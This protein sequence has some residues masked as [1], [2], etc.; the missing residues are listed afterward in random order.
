MW[1]ALQGLCY[2]SKRSVREFLF[3]YFLFFFLTSSSLVSSAS[4][5][6]GGGRGEG[7]ILVGVCE[8][9]FSKELLWFLREKVFLVVAVENERRLSNFFCC[10]ICTI[11]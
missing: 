4:E 7:A 9:C 6:R 1:T 11:F 5:G 3:F 8:I 10:L 2:T